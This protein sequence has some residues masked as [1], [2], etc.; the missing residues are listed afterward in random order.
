MTT[1][2]EDTLRGA[3]VAEVLDL[4]L[5]VPAAETIST[6]CLFPGQNGEILNLVAASAAAV[7]AVV[8]D[9]RAITE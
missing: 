1:H 8:A 6:E 3:R 7:G 4:T 2:A 9:Q 5:A